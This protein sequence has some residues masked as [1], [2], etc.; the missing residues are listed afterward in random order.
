MYPLCNGY[1]RKLQPC[2]S[3]SLHQAIQQVE[4]WIRIGAA[5]LKSKL[6]GSQ[7]A[8]ILDKAEQTTRKYGRHILFWISEM[9]GCNR[10]VFDG[11]EY[12]TRSGQFIKKPR[13]TGKTREIKPKKE[14]RKSNRKNNVKRKTGAAS[15]KVSQV[16]PSKSS[17]EQDT[18]KGRDRQNETGVDPNYGRKDQMVS[19]GK[20]NSTLTKQPETSEARKVPEKKSTPSNYT[21]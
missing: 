10:C 20:D 9:A 15:S 16:H 2:A 11:Q 14:V 19:R 13:K 17:K 21:S 1:F 3:L 5:L 8:C 7:G 4:K 6:N 18:Q 12:I